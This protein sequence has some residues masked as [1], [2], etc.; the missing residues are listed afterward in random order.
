MLDNLL[1]PV[2]LLI[3]IVPLGI[4]L[5]VYFLPT[6]IAV[7]RR[8]HNRLP[9]ALLNLLL[10]WTAIGWIAALIWSVTSPNPVQVVVSPQPLPP[11][12]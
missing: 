6:I 4:A 8:H 5:A 7:R 9:I 2:H 3:L 11:L 1:T 12:R 10:G